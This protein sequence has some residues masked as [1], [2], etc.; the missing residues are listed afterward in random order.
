MPES[1]LPSSIAFHYVKS[2]YFRVIHVN[3]AFG[4]FSP[5]GDLFLSIYSERPTLPDVT[6]QTVESTGQLGA[7]IIEQRKGREGIVRELEAGLAMNVRT[8]RSL[9]QWLNERIA[10]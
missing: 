10:L 6:V 1:G 3:G 8:A 9:V 4:G 5:D 2:N 7:E